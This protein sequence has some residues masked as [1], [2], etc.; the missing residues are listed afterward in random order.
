MADPDAIAEGENREVTLTAR[1]VP[2]STDCVV[3]FP[4]T[5][6]LAV[7]GT[8][9]NEATPGTDY[10]P[11]AAPAQ[12]EIAACAAGVSW[13]VGLNT[14]VDTEN[15]PDETVT[16]TPSIAG[17]PE[18]APAA[19]TAAAVTLR[20]EPGVALSKRRLSFREGRSGSYTVALTAA[21]SGNV[22]VTPRVRDNGD[23]TVSPLR[24]V[25]TTQNWHEAQAVTVSA[26]DDADEEDDTATVEHGVSGGGY[27]GVSAGA[28][29]VAVRD[30]DGANELGAVQLG[31]ASVVAGG[32]LA[33]PGEGKVVIGRVE[34]AYNGEWGTVCDD[35]QY[36]GNRAPVL[37]CRIAGYKTGQMARQPHNRDAAASS[38]P[39]WLDDVRCLAGT[40]DT[41]TRLDQCFHVGVGNHNCTHGEDLWVQ[42]EGIL[43]EGE[44]PALGSVPRLL[45]GDAGGMEGP[46]DGP[47]TLVFSV[48]L[49]PAATAEVTV[50]YRTRDVPGTEQ[51]GQDFKGLGA[52]RA[53]A[54]G[55]YTAIPA[56]ADRTLT[57]APGETSKTI[58]VAIVNDTEEDS[59]EVFQVVLS[60]ATGALIG[61]AVGEGLIFNHD[62]PTAAF[63]DL[64][65]FH[66][67]QAFTVELAFSEPV[68]ADADRLRAALA[69]SGGSV[70]AVTQ[71][72]GSD[73]RSWQ[74]TVQP[75]GTQAAVVLAL[76]ATADCAAADA[77]CTGDGRPLSEVLEAAVAA[78]P[79]VR[80]TGASVTSG[81]GDNGT[82][83]TGERVEAEVRFSA[84]VTVT[85][86]PDA[87]PTLGILLDGTRREAAYVG[88]SGTDTL[89]FGHTVTA[90]DD[91]ATRARI[92]ANGARA[93]RRG[94][95]RRP[96]RGR[97]YRVRGRAVCE[98][99]G[100]HAG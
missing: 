78:A 95:A 8:A 17:T 60:E 51:L 96:G 25:F 98:G 41:A 79:A 69:V 30:T 11:I 87:R 65:A 82:W 40:H 12:Q 1:I 81:P 43:D 38:V 56:S 84:A 15:D 90:E 35:R 33:R 42:C 5:V 21:P 100:G 63:R 49:T 10:A 6:A 88:G 20:Q 76:P 83:D 55:D 23:V 94:P 77:I 71:T 4:V 57:F 28:V 34:V 26:A 39:I 24:L 80:A 99:G 16:F 54:P 97:R 52:T 27:G 50:K 73:A 85:G 37:A 62:P 7:G 58:A 93:Q 3:R 46:Y 29:T 91:G 47:D 19:L 92:V 86:L 75:A 32:G 45:M 18:I 36:L 13:Q 14:T 48:V 2:V 70:T 9:E 22:T 67:G 59:Y 44:S 89:T 72:A 74:V 53:R 61:D 64:P 68:E 66:G 31:D